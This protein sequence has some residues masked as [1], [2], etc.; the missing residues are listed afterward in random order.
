AA[1]AARAPPGVAHPHRVAALQAAQVGLRVLHGPRGACRRTARVQGP[2]GAQEARLAVPGARL[3]SAG[4]AMSPPGADRYRVRADGDTHI[5]GF[6]AGE[7]C[8]S[9]AR[10]LEQ[11]GVAI[12]RPAETEVVVHGVGAHGLAPSPA[13]LDMGNAGTAMRLM[14]GVLAPQRF[15]S[16][17]IG[18]ESLMRRPMERVAVPLQKMG[19]RIQTQQGRPTVLIRGTPQLRALHYSLPVASAP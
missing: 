18:D 5:S 12:E 10:A 13:P 15:D 11:L 2:G 16:T 3:L 14:M 7:D 8:L 4:G 17:L 6:L 19:A 1:R 9:T